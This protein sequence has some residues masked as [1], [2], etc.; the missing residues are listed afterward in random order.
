MS[1]QTP[2][3]RIKRSEQIPSRK[4]ATYVL[5]NENWGWLA[6]KP[7]ETRMPMWLHDKRKAVQFDNITDA[8]RCAGQWAFG[9]VAVRRADRTYEKPTAVGEYAALNAQLTNIRAE[10]R[11]VRKRMRSNSTSTRRRT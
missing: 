3:P 9:L 7:T 11:D 5:Y 6:I 1:T 4:S 8:R 10:G 2:P